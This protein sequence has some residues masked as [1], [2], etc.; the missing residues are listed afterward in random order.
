MNDINKKKRLDFYIQHFQKVNN[1]YDSQE[2][3]FFGKPSTVLDFLKGGNSDGYVLTNNSII[4]RESYSKGFYDGYGWYN[5]QI[6]YEVF[7]SKHLLT[8][9]TRRPNTLIKPITISSFEFLD[10]YLTEKCLCIR[11]KLPFDYIDSVELLSYENFW[12]Q[13]NSLDISSEKM[14]SD[15]YFG[16]PSYM[17]SDRAKFGLVNSLIKDEQ[18]VYLTLKLHSP[19]ELNE[20]FS[21]HR[22]NLWFRTSWGAK[23]IGKEKTGRFVIILNQEDANKIYTTYQ[24]WKKTV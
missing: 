16:S 15:I 6:I 8:R 7:K 1:L 17:D 4:S 23:F 24:N 19:S 9:E 18:G 13:Y 10:D 5:K 20:K 12:K 14:F 21:T 2:E 22:N 3:N 11:E